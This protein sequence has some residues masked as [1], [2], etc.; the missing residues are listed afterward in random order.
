MARIILPTN[1][2]IGRELLSLTQQ[3]I[4]AS[5]AVNRLKAQ[6]EIITVNGTAPTQLESSAEAQIPA[7]MG[8][9]IYNGITQIKTALDGLASLVAAIDQ[10]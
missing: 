10:G 7:A 2:L 9:A 1:T 3:I 5:Q 4:G 8:L 6:V